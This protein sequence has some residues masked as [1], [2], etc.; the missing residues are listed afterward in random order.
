MR[1]KDK[2]QNITKLRRA[3]LSRGLMRDCLISAMN[4]RWNPGRSDAMHA[5]RPT[6]RTGNNTTRSTGPHK[7]WAV[8]PYEEMI[9]RRRERSGYVIGD[10]GCGEAKSLGVLFGAF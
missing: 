1:F 7:D 9:R 3:Y 5:F 4:Q 8:V 2:M 10:F 6:P